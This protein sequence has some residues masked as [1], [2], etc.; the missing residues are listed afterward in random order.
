MILEKEIRKLAR[1][2]YWQTLY[3]MSKDGHDIQFFD[4][5]N[6]LSGPQVSLLQWLRTY[7]MLYTEKAQKESCFLTDNV[8]KCDQRCNAYLHIRRIRIENDWLQHQHDKKADDAKSRHS[9]KNND[10]VS[11][12][13][14][15]LM[16]SGTAGRRD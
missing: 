3:S 1:S 14:V 2:D 8:I 5:V 6:S 16:E 13:D 12:I 9:F 10:N 4:N 15:K 11:V 7:D